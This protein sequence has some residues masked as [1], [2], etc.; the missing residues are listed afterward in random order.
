MIRSQFWSGTTGKAITI[1]GKDTRILATYLLTCEHANMLGLYRLPIL[2]I[3]EEAGLKRKEVLA[4]L[5][6]LKAI[7]F[8]H[9]DDGAE[10][11]WVIEMARFQLDLSPGEALNESDHRVKGVMKIYKQLAKNPFLG[12]FYDRYASYLHLSSRRD[13][14]LESNLLISPLQAPSKPLVRGD[15]PVHLNS[16]LRKGEMGETKIAPEPSAKLTPEEVQAHWNAIPGVKPCKVLGATI[17]DRVRSRLREYPDATWWESLFQRIGSSDFLCGRTSGKEGSFHA[18]LDWVLGPKNLDK[19][20]AGNYDSLAITNHPATLTC[21]KRVQRG[22]FLK[23]C[24]APVDPR[25]QPAEPRCTEHLSPVRPLQ[26][27]ATC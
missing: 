1:S 14:L 2:Y 27:A 24:G 13:F 8:A 9:Y 11:V 19:I 7:G 23:A 10:F 26:E 21:S 5:E 25:S 17:R 18:S 4:A 3:A 12:P 15:V 6:N 20:L 16:S 22:Q